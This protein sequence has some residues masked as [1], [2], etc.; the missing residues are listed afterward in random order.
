MGLSTAMYTA[1][2]GMN[3]NQFQIDTTG[4]NIANVNTTAY[5]GN[6]ASFENQFSL[7]LSGGTGPGDNT[8]GTN[9]SQLGLGSVVG[10]VQ[11]NHQAGA[12][13]T[14]GVPTDMAIEGNGFFVVETSDQQA[15]TR[16]GTFKIDSN[17]TLVTAQGYKVKGYG[18]DDNFNIV[19]SQLTDLEIPLGSM[20]S[21]RATSEAAFDGNLN[22]DG[23][24]GTQGTIL[25]SQ[26]LEEG[27]GTAATE[28]SLLVDLYDADPLNQANPLFAE[29]DVITTDNVKKGARQMPEKSFE[30]EAD[31][32]LGDFLDFLN[33][34]I[35]LNEDDDTPGSAGITVSEDAGDEGKIVIEGNVGTENALELTRSSIRS[36][37]SNFN[38][39]F[40]WEETQEANGE[41]VF[42]SFM[43][44]DSLGT[45]V[46]VDLTM[47]LEE[48]S[49]TGNVWRYYAQ[50]NDDTDSDP[51]LGTGT[52]TF[53][54]DGQLTEVSGDT[55]SI[56]REDTG[57][58]TPLDIELDFENVTGLTTSESTMVMTKQDGYG[59]GTLNSFSVG[60]DGVITGSFSNG[61][62]RSLGQLAMANF[63]NPEGLISDS[64]NLYM[65]GA[66][67][68]NPVVSTPETL[69]AGR[70]IGGALELSNVDITREFIGLITASTGFSASGRVLSTS[71]DLLNE[72]LV[73][74]R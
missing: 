16:D 44:Y 74:A 29:G 46:Q 71:N 5:K 59:T 38:T 40:A 64:N 73:I 20:T 49:N 50:S 43:A 56:D 37:N 55:L 33:D 27:P 23:T 34:A 18:V 22:A 28:D 17:N 4:D 67:S 36:T 57:A 1:L 51:V 24:I 65:V 62:T 72:L 63:T 70:V 53:D 60:T 10:G 35:G 45:D 21:A 2:T 11:R 31:S 32:T 3:T 13:E 9:P 19:Q 47:V 8:G 68:G 25:M 12:I 39:P 15:Y 26:A 54:N 69:G 48:K 41:S 6:R 42:T 30:V 52:L 7:M 58:L 66:N 61:L 14:T